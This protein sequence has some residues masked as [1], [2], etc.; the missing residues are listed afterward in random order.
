MKR[1]DLHILYATNDCISEKKLLQ[2]Y[3]RVLLAISGGQDSI[4]ILKILFQ[5]RSKWG[6]KLGILHCDHRWNSLGTLQAIYVSQLSSYMEL[7]Y[8]QGITTNDLPSETSARNWRYQLLKHIAY[9][10]HYTSIVTAHTASD[11]IE[12]FLYNLMRGSGISGIHSLRWKRVL[13]KNQF[14][15][16]FSIYQNTRKRL[17]IKYTQNTS[18]SHEKKYLNVKIIRPLLHLTRLQIRFLLDNWKLP[19]WLDH[20]NRSIQISRNRIRHRILPYLRLYFYPKIDQLISQWIELASCEIFYIKKLIR[21]LRLKMEISI[22]DQ[23]EYI[24]YMALPIEKLRVLPIFIQRHIIKQFIEHNISRKM[25]FHQIEHLRLK[26]SY[27][28]LKQKSSFILKKKAKL[29]QTSYM[30]YYS[31]SKTHMKLTNYFLF[32]NKNNLD[33]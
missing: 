17:N 15:D 22:L 21:H 5:L 9:T 1:E 11:R 16:I 33:Y 12:T 23:H 18:F 19:V 27:S 4:C 3:E 20:T 7:D 32:I 24:I 14:F 29:M 13:P 28:I 26:Y 10:H 2:P 8:Y 6:W 25:R 30:N 31:S